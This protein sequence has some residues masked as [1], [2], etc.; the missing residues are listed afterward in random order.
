M[1]TFIEFDYSRVEMRITM[2]RLFVAF[3][4]LSL[5]LLLSAENRMAPEAALERL[6]AGNE[7]YT[8]DQFTSPDRT[9]ERRLAVVS[10]QQPFAAI[11]GCSDSRVA[12]EII[13]DQGI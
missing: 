1:N 13:F 9:E 10:T 2:K 3:A 7:R 6:V 12:P 11:L 8:K 5:Q 4:M